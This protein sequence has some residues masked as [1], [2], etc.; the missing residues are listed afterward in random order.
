METKREILARSMDFDVT[1]T[2]ALPWQPDVRFHK[3]IIFLL[4]SSWKIIFSNYLLQFYIFYHFL[5]K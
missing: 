4:K 5:I 1:P 3:K 2:N